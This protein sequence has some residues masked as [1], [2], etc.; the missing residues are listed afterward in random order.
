MNGS[1]K[2]QDQDR[3][4]P[5]KVT[6]IK[7]SLRWV[8]TTRCLNFSK[9]F[10]CCLSAAEEVIYFKTA[11]LCYSRVCLHHPK[12]VAE[13]AASFDPVTSTQVRADVYKWPALPE[14]IRKMT[15]LVPEISRAV[16]HSVQETIP[17]TS[18]F[19]GFTRSPD[20]ALKCGVW[21]GWD[22]GDTPFP[23]TKVGHIPESCLRHTPR[24]FPPSLK[25]CWPL[26][27]PCR[28]LHGSRLGLTTLNP[29]GTTEASTGHDFLRTYTFYSLQ[30]GKAGTVEWVIWTFLNRVTYWL[31]SL[32]LFQRPKVIFTCQGLHR[33]WD[34]LWWL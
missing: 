17:L 29:R 13:A 33:F 28:A 4:W 20:W 21:T 8:D 30:P 6:L 14:E 10:S 25:V 31:K 2:T 23:E 12:L 3:R 7:I 11:G 34:P 18:G 26:D 16:G 19:G 24:L 9:S 5:F 27:R 32:W 15:W 1:Y 22:T